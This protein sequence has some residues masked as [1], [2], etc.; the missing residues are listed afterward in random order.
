MFNKI[1]NNKYNFT[2]E[3]H[4]QKTKNKFLILNVLV[5]GL[6]NLVGCS[7]T[8]TL[9]KVPKLN[10]QS[11]N[12][13]YSYCESCE[14]ATRLEADVYKPLEPDVPSVEVGTNV[15][16]VTPYVQHVHYTQHAPSAH[17]THKHHHKKIKRKKHHKSQCLEWSK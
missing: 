2:K 1:Q 11:V 16:T 3:Q 6:F 17:N 12:Q 14:P 4:G 9:P 8:P 15:P 7:T 5:C 13:F 10:T